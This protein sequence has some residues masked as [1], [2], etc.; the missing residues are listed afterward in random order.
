[1]NGRRAAVL[2]LTLL[3]LAL[4]A[5]GGSALSVMG[6]V[7]SVAGDRVAATL[8]HTLAVESLLACLPALR[9]ARP[10]SGQDDEADAGGERLELT[11][12]RCQVRCVIR[13]ESV[14]LQ[15]GS[16]PGTEDT[17]RRLRELARAHH[18]P[19]ED[20]RSLPVA[21][22]T[23]GPRV[24]ALAWFDQIVQP[25]EIEEVFRWRFR[26]DVDPADVEGKTWSDLVT[27]WRSPSGEP[28]ALEVETR[29]ESDSR[30]WY[31]VVTTD[32]HSS[33]VLHWSAIP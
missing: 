10:L 25:T 13:P 8:Q 11:V 19:E 20:V 1:V 21:A 16:D 3:L 23:D 14:K 30:L 26:D 28:L 22:Q 18:L 6:A 24:A 12:G 33:T 7:E 32:G 31:V 4:L 27:F 17:A 5:A 9:A 2:V 29:I 15:L